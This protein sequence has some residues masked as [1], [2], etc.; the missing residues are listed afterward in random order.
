MRRTRALGMTALVALALLALLAPRAHAET[1]KFEYA[2]GPTAVRAFNEKNERELAEW[3]KAQPATP[4]KYP[5]EDNVLNAPWGAFLKSIGDHP[6]LILATLVPHVGAQLRGQSPAAVV[7]WPWSIPFGPGFTAS[8]PLQGSSFTVREYR[9]HRAVFEPG[10]F[11]SPQGAG[12][13]IRPGYRFFYH[14]SE[15]VMGLGF[16]AGTT[17]EIAN[18]RVD[19]FRASVSPEVILQFGHCCDPGYFNLTVRYDRFFAGDAFDI[20]SGNLGFVFF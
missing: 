18:P 20:P 4:Y 17:I 2:D 12:F 14:P 10:L 6:D 13:Y 3:S 15:W 7:S 8:R 1:P 19:P 11:S 16:G 5:R 9:A